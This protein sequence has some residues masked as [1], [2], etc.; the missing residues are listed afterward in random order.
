MDK[1]P[2]FKYKSSGFSE[3]GIY[4]ELYL[5][6][7]SKYQ[8]TLYETLTRGFDLKKVKEHFLDT[9]KRPLIQSV[10]QY[11]PQWSNYSDEYIDGMEQFYWGY[12]LY[13]VD[14]VFNSR[15]QPGIP[16]EE[17]TQVVR[18]MF[19]PDVGAM[20][21]SLRLQ[22]LPIQDVVDVV[23]GFL[24][25]TGHRRGEYWPSTCNVFD[26]TWLAAN[27]APNVAGRLPSSDIRQIVE[28]VERWYYEVGLFLF[29]YVIF[30][31][32]SRIRHLEES[33]EIKSPEE[34]LWLTSFWNLN[35]NRVSYQFGESDG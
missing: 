31:I 13:E 27:N 32:C 29:G 16:I 12:S 25:A 18:I 3:P 23:A 28:Y 26:P 17:R 8:E 5:P 33:M 2:P 21:N 11:H 4:V 15:R 30:E 14:G 35:V 19:L 10:L 20:I 9:T 7:K 22:E 1:V 34:E 6:K 24:R